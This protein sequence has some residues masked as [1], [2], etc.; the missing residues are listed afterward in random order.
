MGVGLFVPV[1]RDRMRG[2]VLRLH[3]GG[4]RLDI[5]KNFF[6]GRVVKHENRAVVDSP[7]LEMF[8]RYIDV[9][10]MDTD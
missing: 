4:F 7:V 8:K 10:L 9:V 5:T 3:Q 2:N 1:T 6:M